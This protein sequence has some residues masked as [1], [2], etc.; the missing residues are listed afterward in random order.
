MSIEGIRF[1][2]VIARRSNRSQLPDLRSVAEI[3]LIRKLCETPVLSD[4]K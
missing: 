3:D 2:A 4:L 1:F